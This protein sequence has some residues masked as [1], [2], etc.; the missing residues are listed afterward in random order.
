MIQ[1]KLVTADLFELEKKYSSKIKPPIY[2]PSLNKPSIYKLYDDRKTK[3]LLKHIEESSVTE[4]EKVFL[5]EAAKRHTVFNYK[6]IADYYAN[7]G[8]EMQELMEESALVI[9]DFNKAIEYGFVDL[10]NE[11][12]EQYL[13]DTENA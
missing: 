4:E 6:I 13:K 1:E 3:E 11:I 8:K 5:R 10:S 7:S 9:I 12:V 2:T